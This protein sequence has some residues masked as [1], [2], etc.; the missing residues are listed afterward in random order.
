MWDK[1]IAFTESQKAFAVDIREP[2]A[3]VNCSRGK[4]T[5]RLWFK[6]FS[7]DTEQSRTRWSIKFKFD[8]VTLLFYAFQN[9]NEFLVYRAV[10]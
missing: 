4:K 1:V 9:R 7:W 5:Q 8:Y 6:N 10:V 3:V 2:F